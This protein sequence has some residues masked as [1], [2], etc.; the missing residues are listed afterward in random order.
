MNNKEKSEKTS[1]ALILNE[2]DNIIIAIDNMEAGE[3]LK[4]FDLRI[5]APILSGQK[6]AKVDIAENSPIFKYGTIIGFA[7]SNIVKDKF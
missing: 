5:D 2:K 7:D 4:N 1:K 3:S 6:I